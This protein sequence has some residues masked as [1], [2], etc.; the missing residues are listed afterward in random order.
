MISFAALLVFVLFIVVKPT[1]GITIGVPDELLTGLPLAELRTFGKDV[2]KLF[3]GYTGVEPNIVEE[4][5]DQLMQQLIRGDI[6]AVLS[7]PRTGI[8]ESFAYAEGSPLATV[9]R[10]LPA[11]SGFICLP[12]TSENLRI[13]K[14]LQ[15]ELSA[16]ST[17][18]ASMDVELTLVPVYAK[19]PQGTMFQNKFEEFLVRNYNA[20]SLIAESV[21]FTPLKP[22]LPNLFWSSPWSW[23]LLFVSVLLLFILGALLFKLNKENR[24]YKEENHLQLEKLSD[25]ESRLLDLQQQIRKLIDDNTLLTEQKERWVQAQKGLEIYLSAFKELLKQLEVLGNIGKADSLSAEFIDQMCNRMKTSFSAKEV[26]LYL[27]NPKEYKYNLAGGHIE[28]IEPVLAMNDPMVYVSSQPGN[29]VEK[30]VAGGKIF[31]GTLGSF[32]T[33]NGFVIV[34]DPAIPNPNQLLSAL[35]NTL[36]LVIALHRSNSRASNME[37]ALSQLEKLQ[38]AR[39]REDFLAALN[40]AGFTIIEDSPAANV[41]NFK[42]RLMRLD[43]AKIA[44][45]APENWPSELDFI[46]L[47]LLEEAISNTAE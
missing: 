5:L 2:L 12:A 41:S 25:V 7:R 21:G 16:T 43:S 47:H 8:T 17:C 42:G 1:F 23:F 39:T 32:E 11:H 18:T 45:V 29:V 15:L 10:A 14:S 44:L 19:T 28:G 6:D 46:I 34:K 26:A 9:S 35:C 4:P 36:Y 20:V 40:H 3:T 31:V 38:G 37:Q 27:Y 13:V 30:N 22:T 24:R 33:E